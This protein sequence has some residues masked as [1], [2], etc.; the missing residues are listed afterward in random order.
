MTSIH[1]KTIYYLNIYIN[2]KKV[3]ELKSFKMIVYE[4]ITLFL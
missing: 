4:N 3:K 1:P 2:I